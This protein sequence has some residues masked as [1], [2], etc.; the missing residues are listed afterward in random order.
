MC[1]H[2]RH[3]LGLASSPYETSTIRLCRATSLSDDAITSIKAVIAR[4]I[5]QGAMVSKIKNSLRKMFIRHQIYKKFSVIE[6]SFLDSL[7]A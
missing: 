2:E 4:M 6:N 1:Q 5:K 3:F 7:F